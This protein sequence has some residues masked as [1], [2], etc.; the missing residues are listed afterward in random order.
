MC[1]KSTDSCTVLIVVLDSVLKYSEL[2]VDEAVT[3]VLLIFQCDR[4]V[5]WCIHSFIHDHRHHHHHKQFYV[6][7]IMLIRTYCK[8]H[9]CLDSS[10]EW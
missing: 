5:L 2:T 7:Y 4:S 3:S 8:D 6:A 1:K 9:G 10:D